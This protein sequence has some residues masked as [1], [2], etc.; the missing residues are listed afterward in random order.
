MKRTVAWILIGLAA[1]FV[2]LVVYGFFGGFDPKGTG[3]LVFAAFFLLATGW[4]IG[5]F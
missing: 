3:S 5:D 2:S 4:I 1:V